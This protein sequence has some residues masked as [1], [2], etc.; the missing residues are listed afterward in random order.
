LNKEIDHFLV[1]KSDLQV[2]IDRG[3]VK[4]SEGR[5]SMKRDTIEAFESPFAMGLRAGELRKIGSRVAI[6]RPSGEVE[7]VDGGS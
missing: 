4:A 2:L 3:L 5:H 1:L 6:V 7:V